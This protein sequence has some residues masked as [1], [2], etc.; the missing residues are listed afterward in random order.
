MH[1]I[2]FI[3]FIMLLL[4]F[5]QIIIINIIYYCTRLDQSHEA[6]ATKHIDQQS[7]SLLDQIRSVGALWIDRP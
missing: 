6:A 3:I 7:C 1:N 4:L 5:H 2:I